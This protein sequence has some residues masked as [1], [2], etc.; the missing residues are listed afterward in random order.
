METAQNKQLPWAGEFKSRVKADFRC[1]ESSE[2]HR[3]RESGIRHGHE[4]EGGHQCI[5]RPSLKVA[6]LSH[7]QAKETVF[8]SPVGPPLAIDHPQELDRGEDYRYGFFDKA[9]LGRL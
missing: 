5:T 1:M 4:A 8:N 7:V 9:A 2:D 6:E 3:T